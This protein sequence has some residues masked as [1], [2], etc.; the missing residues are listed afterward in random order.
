MDK[1]ARLPAGTDASLAEEPGDAEDTRAEAEKYAQKIQDL[2]LDA[3]S[4]EKLLKECEAPWQNGRQSGR[5]QR[6]S[7]LSDTVIGLRR[8]TFTK[9]DLNQAHARGAGP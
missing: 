5:N 4:E 1:P 6:D 9:D 3:A 8:H 7:Q 2:H